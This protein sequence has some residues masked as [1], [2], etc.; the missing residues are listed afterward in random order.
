M[1]KTFL[2]PLTLI[3]SLSTTSMAQEE[4]NSQEAR[5]AAFDECLTSLGIERPA[6]GE[7]PQAMDESVREQID[8]CMQEKGYEAPKHR[9]QGPPRG[10]EGSERR[11]PRRGGG[12]TR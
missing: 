4:G 5:R 11:P 7:R 9:P 1:M 6:Q 8:A 3:L 10:E 12:G 2:V